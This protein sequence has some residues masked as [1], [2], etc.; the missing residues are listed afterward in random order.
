MADFITALGFLIAVA[1][2]FLVVVGFFVREH[3]LWI[4]MGTLVVGSALLVTGLWFNGFRSV[5]QVVEVL[6]E[7]K[8]PRSVPLPDGE[9]LFER[10]RDEGFYS[11]RA[12]LERLTRD[13][14]RLLEL[15]HINDEYWPAM[16]LY[17]TLQDDLLRSEG[18]FWPELPGSETVAIQETWTRP[19]ELRALS[20]EELEMAWNKRQEWESSRRR[21]QAR[22]S[23]SE[24]SAQRRVEKSKEVLRA[25]SS[26]GTNTA[27]VAG[28]EIGKWHRHYSETTHPVKVALSGVVK[29]LRNP[30][31]AS[32]LGDHCRALRQALNDMP[33]S[34]LQSPDMQVGELLRQAYGS[35][36]R[37]ASSCMKGE[38]GRVEFFLEHSE[39]QLGAAAEALRPYSLRP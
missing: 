31:Q 13:L 28:S 22:K 37:I 30:R 20:A 14:E 39:R 10:L 38:I 35:M 11:D 3:R 33:K 23:G 25:L 5:S 29:S 6:Q 7:G 36:G 4:P 9:D 8:L 34:S 32:S 16:R 21:R 24:M 17:E 2:L 12:E 1:G 27:A 26:G 19:S 18:D 15:R